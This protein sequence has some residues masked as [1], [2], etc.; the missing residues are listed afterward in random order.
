[1]SSETEVVLLGVAASLIAGLATGAGALPILF[2]EQFSD[3][4]L[5]ALLGFAAGVMLAAAAFSDVF[6]NLKAFQTTSGSFV[7]ITIPIF[8]F[9][10]S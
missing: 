4:M 2:R 10:H 1:M 3:R 9:Y 8:N 7:L 6:P 5:D